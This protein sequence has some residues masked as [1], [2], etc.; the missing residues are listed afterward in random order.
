M[1][2]LLEDFLAFGFGLVR[3]HCHRA[4][5]SRGNSPSQARLHDLQVAAA[6][7]DHE[8]NDDQFDDIEDEVVVVFAVRISV[9]KM[10]E[11][12]ATC[13]RI[14]SSWNCLNFAAS[15]WSFFTSISFSSLNT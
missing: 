6:H 15:A 11:T 14:I 3:L 12:R 4:D 5:C 10:C 2:M 1:V 13:S 7:P 8:P 9:E